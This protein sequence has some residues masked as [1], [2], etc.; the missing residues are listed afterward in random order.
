MRNAIELEDNFLPEN[1]PIPHGHSACGDEDVPLVEGLLELVH[2]ALGLVD[3][4]ARVVEGHPM[5]SQQSG[6]S[7]LVAVADGA[8]LQG[9]AVAGVLQ[10]VA[11]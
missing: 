2:Q 6:Q 3:G 10:L 1:V 5:L 11:S 8:G 9:L 4:D 7:G